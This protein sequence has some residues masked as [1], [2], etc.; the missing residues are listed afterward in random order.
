MP[1]ELKR[2][3]GVPMPSPEHLRRH[4]HASTG[5][6]V[7]L[8]ILVL[9]A[10]ALLVFVFL[11][12]RDMAADSLTAEA[13]LQA[14]YQKRLDNTMETYKQR[15][16]T[17]P[18]LFYNGPLF[19]GDYASGIYMIDRETGD[20]VAVHRA[21]R[22]DAAHQLYAV[23]Q[24][25]YDGRVIVRKIPEGEV[26]NVQLAYLDVETGTIVE[27]AIFENSSPMFG[28]HAVSPTEEWVVYV[29]D[30]PSAHEGNP[31]VVVMNLLTGERETVGELT[32]DEEYFSEYYGGLGGAGGARIEWV[33]QKC[34]NV[35]VYQPRESGDADEGIEYHRYKEQRVY[36]RS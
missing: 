14:E 15:L 4:G 16:S 6:F 32:E 22:G 3:A 31:N 27:D 25:N 36:C 18:P 12:Q 33:D 13:E 30:N 10:L 29:Y 23:P 9:A 34:V 24:L 5:L 26:P 20:E 17:V 1:E 19:S 7:V 11:R 2:P 8:F 21:T 28:S 35:F